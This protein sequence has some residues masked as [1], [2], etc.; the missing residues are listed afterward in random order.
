MPGGRRHS[1][2]ALDARQGKDE[3]GV[4]AKQSH[5]KGKEAEK[6]GND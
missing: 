5:G 1:M 3:N 4:R 6:R 2:N